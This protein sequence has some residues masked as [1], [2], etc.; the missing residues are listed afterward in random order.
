M[1]LITKLRINYTKFI[2]FG[3]GVFLLNRNVKKF[4]SLKFPIKNSIRIY[5][6]TI[7]KN[8]S[9]KLLR[10]PPK[11]DQVIDFDI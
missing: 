5:L 10:P 2:I 9:T 11:T 4:I 1:I 8:F 6:Y 7:F 3:I